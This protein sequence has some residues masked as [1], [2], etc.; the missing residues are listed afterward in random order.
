MR[1]QHRIK[2]DILGEIIKLKESTDGLGIIGAHSGDILAVAY[3]CE[4]QINRAEQKIKNITNY[5]IYKFK[6]VTIP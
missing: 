3:Q 1:N 4:D 2:Y 6:T 5:E